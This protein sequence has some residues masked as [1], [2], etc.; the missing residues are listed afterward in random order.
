MQFSQV[1]GRSGTVLLPSGSR[2]AI[3]YGVVPLT[4]VL[5]SHRPRCE[6]SL[7]LQAN[8]GY[9]ERLQ[10]RMYSGPRAQRTI[11]NLGKMLEAF[12]AKRLTDPGCG[13]ELGPPVV[14]R[15]TTPAS[16]EQWICVAGNLRLILL[17][18]AE[19]IGVQRPTWPEAR[20][21]L[22][23]YARCLAASAVELK[24]ELPESLREG[25]LVRELTE[26][27]MGSEEAAD[28]DVLRQ[29]A[30]IN[31]QSD[32]AFTRSKDPAS[33]GYSYARGLMDAAEDSR[34]TRTTR[35]RRER[36][37]KTIIGL[38]E[39]VFERGAYTARRPRWATSLIRDL[40]RI[41]V[42]P[43]GEESQ[44]LQPT[45]DRITDL[46]TRYARY[47][48][49]SLA[50][51][52]PDVVDGLPA[53]F[54][55]RFLAIAPQ[56]IR[57]RNLGPWDLRSAIAEGGR[58]LKRSRMHGQLSASKHFREQHR[59][60]PDVSSRWLE[61][62]LKT[63][64][65]PAPQEPQSSL[66]EVT[67]SE[68]AQ[69]PDEPAE[70]TARAWAAIL[71]FGAGRETALFRAAL[72][73]WL[74]LAPT[75]TGGQTRLLSADFLE[76]QTPPSIGEIFGDGIPA[77]LTWLH[78]IAP[79]RDAPLVRSRVVEV[80]S[81]TLEVQSTLAHAW[82]KGGTALF[83]AAC[84]A[85]PRLVGAQWAVQRPRG[86]RGYASRYSYGE[87][88]AYVMVRHTSWHAG[89][90]EALPSQPCDRQIRR[91]LQALQAL[92]EGRLWPVLCMAAPV[93]GEPIR[94]GRRSSGSRSA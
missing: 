78:E 57:L 54:V 56:L 43:E 72:E 65:L 77:L 11:E 33:V 85:W 17:Q 28:G 58:F 22:R 73:R 74:E 81:I 12:D 16:G 32:L 92:D 50:Y 90:P 18:L 13:S 9:P 15:R 35:E 38:Q 19:L 69:S 21:I 36:A 51:D 94:R 84:D 55:P 24:I 3:R 40:R 86:R 64:G 79:E 1:F 93:L 91:M 59:R 68:W 6:P 44:L 47:V 75:Q 53:P 83:E 34:D 39:A 63:F 82:R 25:V 29:L 87:W 88:F 8:E 62:T 7:H 26:F 46:G 30:T 80:P 76:S 37:R 20:G 42:I 10:H 5:T 27:R 23:S 61:Q 48:V 60:H 66:F 67:D 14:V 49:S 70:R 71:L 2:H 4:A 89:H 45:A 31:R 52:D 41:D